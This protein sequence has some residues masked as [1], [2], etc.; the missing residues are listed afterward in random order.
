MSP[1]RVELSPL[2]GFLAVIVLGLGLL[3]VADEV[4]EGDARSF[5]DAVFRL[6]RSPDAPAWLTEMARDVT[7]LGSFTVLGIV[8]IVAAAGL[9]LAG[10]VHNGPARRPCSPPAFPPAT[11]C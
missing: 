11:P 6:L 4:M 5:D 8:L 3:Y 7:A 10:R 2:V 9:F 1:S